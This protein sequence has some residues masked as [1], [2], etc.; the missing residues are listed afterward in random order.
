MA[1]EALKH[2]EQPWPSGDA[3]T[4]ATLIMPLMH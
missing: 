2:S 1:R 4:E 3:A